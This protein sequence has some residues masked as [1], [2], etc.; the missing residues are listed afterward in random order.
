MGTVPGMTK[1]PSPTSPTSQRRALSIVGLGSATGYG[2]GTASLEKGLLSGVSAAVET[3]DL[4][5]YFGKPA[6][7]ATIAEDGAPEAVGTSR[8]Q[9]ALSAVVSEA[10][11]DATKRGWEP[12]RRVA[13]VNGM[14]LADV[15]AAAAFY[16]KGA[17][18]WRARRYLELMPSTAVSNVMHEHDWHGPLLNVIAMCASGNVALLT[19][20]G[21]LASGAATDVVVT[22][23]DLS[24]HGPHL[25]Q[26][27]A[28]GVLCYDR[29]ALEAC[30]PYQE[31]S[32]GYAFGEAATA[33]ICSA[34]PD[35]AYA[36]M[37]GGAASADGHHPTSIDLSLTHLRQCWRDA[38]EN[39]GVDP[40]EVRYLNG[41]GPGTAQSDGSEAKLFREFLSP[42]ARAYSVKPLL[43]HCQGAAAGVEIVAMCLGYASGTIGAPAQI[44]PASIPVLD[45]PT[46][47]EPGLTIKSSI[48]MGGHNTL[49]VFAPPQP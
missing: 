5:L 26:F 29:P 19:A 25:E 32:R 42:D 28:M 35:G 39:A 16:S 27:A 48:G 37:L 2:W 43:G 9:R 3:P 7:A 13:L 30:R 12:G 18:R 36:H 14:V 15:P 17:E 47:V 49:T 1:T 20:A 21:L 40:R 34:R 6:Y 10:A 8:Y 38:F 31:G 23:T 45:G 11:A 4:S 44:A 33:M 41:H 24:C 46:A 22:T